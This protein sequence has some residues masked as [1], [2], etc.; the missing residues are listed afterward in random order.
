MEFLGNTHFSNGNHTLALL[1]KA[2]WVHVN[3]STSR[4]HNS[5][6]SDFLLFHSAYMEMCACCC[7]DL[8]M[9][10]GVRHFSVCACTCATYNPV[11]CQSTS[12][13]AWIM[14]SKHRELKPQQQESSCKY[15]H[16]ALV[17]ALQIIW[18]LRILLPNIAMNWNKGTS[19]T[20]EVFVVQFLHGHKRLRIWTYPE[21]GIGLMKW[22]VLFS[23]LRAEK[24]FLLCFCQ[25][26]VVFWLTLICEICVQ[27]CS[28]QVGTPVCPESILVTEQLEPDLALQPAKYSGNMSVNVE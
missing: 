12:V 17:M 1:P 18:K 7:S 10:P 3:E 26:I 28:M 20:S 22:L 19:L 13:T 4:K 23:S 5:F 14:L 9:S 11:L 24:N 16:V 15:T 6:L 8:D 21:P 27:Q 25:S 2:L